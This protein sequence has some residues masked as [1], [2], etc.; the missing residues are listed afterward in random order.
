MVS[1]TNNH[2]EGLWRSE[3]RLIPRLLVTLAVLGLLT[4]CAKKEEPKIR[5][6]VRPVKLLTVVSSDEALQRRFPGRVRAAER[7]ELAFQVG[8]PL[9]A[10][11]AEEGEKVKKG[12]VLARID[13]RNFE[14][15]L[16]NARGRMARA[17]AS[18]SSAQTEY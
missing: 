1:K 8:G 2:N 5:K 16:N 4:A 6:T 15:E 14:T 13:P 11:E 18:L 7:V 3:F 12:D 9:V 10:L 17:Q